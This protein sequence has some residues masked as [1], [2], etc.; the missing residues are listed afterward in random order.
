[1]KNRFHRIL[2]FEGQRSFTADEV[3]K[4]NDSLVII[5]GP[6]AIGK[7]T[8]SRILY[9]DHSFVYVRHLTT[10]ESRP[11]DDSTEILTCGQEEFEGRL[12][13]REFFLAEVTNVAYCKKKTLGILIEDLKKAIRTGKK[14][15]L[16]VSPEGASVIIKAFPHAL[17]VVVVAEDYSFFAEKRNGDGELRRLWGNIPFG[18]FYKRYRVPEEN[19]RFVENKI[20]DPQGSAKIIAE[21]AVQKSPE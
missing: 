16:N 13:N 17:M 10:R 1:M 2:A 4:L 9:K 6:K 11:D 19:L 20:G 3:A 21:L 14:I 15:L 18:T 8:L 7:T 5:V 12:G